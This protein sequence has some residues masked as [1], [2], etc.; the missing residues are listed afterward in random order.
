MQ[1][2]DLQRETE[3][4]AD[5]VL[6]ARKIVVFTGAGVSTES[7]I[8]DFRS[9][10]GIWD[11]FDPEDFTY[12]KFLTSPEARKRFW[13]LF[14]DKTFLGARPNAAHRAIAE[15]ESLSKLDCVITQNI[16]NLH[17]EAGNSPDKVIE[18]HGTM[19]YCK[20]L[21]CG[22]RFTREEIEGQLDLGIETPRCDECNGLVKSATISF[23]EA[24]P[25]RETAE[26]QRRSAECDLFIAIGSSLV[27]YPA[28]YM[29][30]HALQAG[31][32]LIIINLDDTHLDGQADVVIRAKAGDAMS[33]ILELVKSKMEG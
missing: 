21:D 32:K 3:K 18:L 14:R 30:L 7:G 19:K 9:P 22:K 20:C 2:L 24:M 17:Q 11:R 5:L 15:L 10:G 12:D 16:D 4:A 8:P 28:A 33:R 13:Q 27:V 25:V 29:P 23:G 6:Q 31:A 1:E 26:A